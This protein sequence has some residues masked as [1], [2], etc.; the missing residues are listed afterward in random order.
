MRGFSITSRAHLDAPLSGIGAAMT[1]ARWNSRGTRMAYAAQSRSLAI[2]E[3]LVH[4]PATSVPRDHVMVVIEVPDDALQSLA[5][6]PDG[7]AQLPYD[8]AVQAAGDAWARSLSSLVLRVPSA[9]VKDEWNLLVNPMHERMAQIRIVGTEA[10]V[11]DARLFQR[12]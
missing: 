4:V 3:M 8:P 11:L 10:L 2:L 7:W 12:A 9:L 1:G 6:L 5:E